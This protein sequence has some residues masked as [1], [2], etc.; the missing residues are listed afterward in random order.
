MERRQFLQNCKLLEIVK[1]SVLV[2]FLIA[3]S[4]PLIE[5]VI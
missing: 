1:G 5:L 3:P 2:D 4:E